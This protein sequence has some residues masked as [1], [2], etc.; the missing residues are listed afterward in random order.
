MHM[1]AIAHSATNTKPPTAAPIMTEVSDELLLLLLL[2]PG[3]SPTSTPPRDTLLLPLVGEGAKEKRR[4]L[5]SVVGVSEPEV[6]CEEE[7]CALLETED[8]LPIDGEAGMLLRRDVE[9]LIEEDGVML[10]KD[11]TGGMLEA[12]VRLLGAK[13]AEDDAVPLDI[14]CEDPRG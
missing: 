2:L 4:G 1:I 14:V 9:V 10:L 7:T 11:A 6:L 5:E 13:V 3:R 12:G 8:M